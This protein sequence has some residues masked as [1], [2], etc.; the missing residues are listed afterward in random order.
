MNSRFEFSV[1]RMRRCSG[2]TAGDEVYAQFFCVEA[3]KRARAASRHLGTIADLSAWSANVRASCES[4]LGLVV[5]LHETIAECDAFFER[6]PGM[7]AP[8]Q[9]ALIEMADVR[10]KAFEN[11]AVVAGWLVHRV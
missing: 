9:Q 10:T 2:N 1:D 7:R 4:H 5:A 8:F 11:V 3:L 6:K